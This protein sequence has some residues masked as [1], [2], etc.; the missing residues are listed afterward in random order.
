MKKKIVFICILIL[1]AIIL[2]FTY[3]FLKKGNNISNKS[4]EDK[5][6]NI[7]NMKNYDATLEIKVETNKN[8]TKYIVE[9]SWKN[10]N[11]SRQKIIE[12]KNIEGVVTEYDGTNLKIINDK[13]NLTTTF[14]N[15]NYV[16][17]NSLWLNSFI[18]SYKENNNSKI[19]KTN[20]EIVLEIKDEKSNKYN[21]YKKLYIDTNTRKTYQINSPRC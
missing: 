11:L 10:G 1:I 2:L 18:K 7:L 3:I 9:Q 19:S 8:T 21:I 20:D 12:P 17:D 13:L 14:E 6:E 5:I 15:Y 16:V 4:D